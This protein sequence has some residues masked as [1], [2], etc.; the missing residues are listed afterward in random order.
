MLCAN[1][2]CDAMRDGVAYYS[3]SN[4]LTEFGARLLSPA[5]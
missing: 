1:G 2:Y 4:H 5:F 3:N